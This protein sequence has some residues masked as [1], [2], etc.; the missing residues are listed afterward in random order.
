MTLAILM[1]QERNI[2]LVLILY[3]I[4][5]FKEFFG[6][7]LIIVYYIIPKNS[8]MKPRGYCWIYFYI[9]EDQKRTLI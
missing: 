7:W 1:E 8:S 3:Y 4:Q 2:K 9:L 5:I 6:I